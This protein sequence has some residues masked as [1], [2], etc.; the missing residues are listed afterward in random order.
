MQ[1]RSILMEDPLLDTSSLLQVA[2]IR[3]ECAA[4][5]AHFVTENARLEALC[6]EQQE[7]ISRLRSSNRCASSGGEASAS[8][9][10][11]MVEVTRKLEHLE[12]ALSEERQN[13]SRLAEEKLASEENHSRDVTML[14]RMLHQ[15]LAENERLQATVSAWEAAKIVTNVNEAID[16]EKEASVLKDSSDGGG[17]VLEEPEMEPRRVCLVPLENDLR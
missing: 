13:S 6:E 16:P 15:A 3:K 5:R 4:L 7:E 1:P 11:A 9:S 8:S 17:V 2:A 14:E 10:Q 12:Q